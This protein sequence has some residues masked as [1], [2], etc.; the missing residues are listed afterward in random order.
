M[1]NIITLLATLGIII[2]SY[3]FYVGRR[4][5][6][7]K[8]YK[9]ICDINKNLSCTKAFTSQHGKILKIQNSLFGILFY[10][11]LTFLSL[12]QTRLIFILS[13]PALII[14]FYLAF[15]SYIKMRNYCIVCSLI[16]II[17]ILIFI[18]S[19]NNLLN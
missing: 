10:T 7:N 15:I 11:V 1:V 6:N 12:S 2:S 16:Y 13:I 3:A 19:Y 18:I 9:P 8:D 5:T 17:N 4:K 14:T